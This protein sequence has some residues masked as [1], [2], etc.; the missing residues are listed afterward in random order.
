MNKLTVAVCVRE[1]AMWTG[2]REK[3]DTVG[4]PIRY[5]R[6]G[7]H[8]ICGK[9][10]AYPGDA[11]SGAVFFSGCTLGCVFCQNHSIAAGNVGKTITTERLADIFLELQEQKGM[12][13]QPGD[14]RTLCTTGGV[15]INPCKKARSVHSGGLQ[16]IRL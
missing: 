12:E 1:T 3:Q 9:N 7:L 13:Y 6:P 4:R 2:H 5:A 16:Y 15:C 11:G 10:P 14:G 8:C